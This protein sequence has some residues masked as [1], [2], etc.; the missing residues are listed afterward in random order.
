MRRVHELITH[1][2]VLLLDMPLSYGDLTDHISGATIA[3]NGKVTWDS[4]I[5]AY[6]FTQTGYGTSN[7]PYISGVYLPIYQ[8][9]AG[10]FGRSFDIY[11]ISS[12]D[13]GGTLILLGHRTTTQNGQANAYS[14][15]CSIS[16]T[17]SPV[18]V[19]KNNWHSVTIIRD[20]TA[21]PSTIITVDGNNG[22]FYQDN[23]QSTFTNSVLLFACGMYSANSK[24]SFCLKN[25][26]YWTL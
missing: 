12:Q 20:E 2:N 7:T 14:C 16:N 1:E 4:S 21:N 6:K 5:G 26:K 13:S 11:P 24:V 17:S 10:R 18:Y 9:G 22:G 15:S 23:Y 3:N 19:S 8:N 25:L